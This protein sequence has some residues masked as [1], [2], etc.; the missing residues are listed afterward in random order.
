MMPNNAALLVAVSLLVSACATTA[1]D[2]S[3]IKSGATAPE[4]YRANRQCLQRAQRRESYAEAGEVVI[5]NWDLFSSCLNSQGW[6][7][8]T[9]ASTRARPH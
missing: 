2:P 7:L 1:P 5:T 8:R 3:W 9:L 4:F 6:F